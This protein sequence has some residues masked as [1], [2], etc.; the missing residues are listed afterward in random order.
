MGV[1][2]RSGIKIFAEGGFLSGSV[3]KA[4]NILSYDDFKLFS[5]LKDKKYDEECIAVIVAKAETYLEEPIP[6]LPLSLYRDKY[7]TGV[8][9][10]FEAQHHKRRDMLFYMA[11]AESYEKKGR[12]TVKI[13]DLAWAILEETTWVIPAHT[14]H[15]PNDPTSTVPETFREDTVPALDLYSA[16]CCALLAVVKYLLGEEL[17]KISPYICERIDRQ[18]YLRG[19]RPFITVSYGWSGEVPGFIDNWLTNITSNILTASALTTK[20]HSLRKRVT[21]RAMK[22]LDN[23]TAYY[24]ED[25]C[26]D[27]GPGYWGG[28]GASLM[29]CLELIE[30]IS[31]GKINVY[32]NPLIRKMGEYIARF[33]IDGKYYLNFA[34]ARPRLEQDGKLI[35]RYGEKCGSEQLRRFGAMVS[36]ENNPNRYY[37][38][39]M[40]YRVLK[41]LYIER[42]PEAEKTKAERAVWYDAYRIA[43][44]RESEDTSQGFFL[45]TKGGDNGEMHNHNDVGCL[46]VYHGGKPVIVDPSHGSYDNGFF[47]P[48]RYDRWFM[49]SSYHSI[50]LANGV[51][52]K[53]GR[54]FKSTDEVC[55]LDNMTVSMNLALAFPEDA[56]I[57]KMIRTV[58]LDGSVV[59]VKDEVTL[60]SDGD[61]RFNYVTVDE[62]KVIAD[63]KLEIA[64]GRVFEYD[65]EKLTLS[66]EKVEN[67]YLPYDDLNFRGTW[68]RDCLW[69]IVLKANGKEAV[70]D[71]S[72]I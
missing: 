47:G 40:T 8:R 1:V 26:C 20:E 67:T 54:A 61:I 33:N 6:F 55:D 29:D 53:A 38:F 42:N 69:R 72:I 60:K 66:V 58:A 41:N 48:T 70:A 9:S 52:E 45:A 68:D 21:E 12:F 14:Y 31:G 16:N 28:A 71:I 2:E 11:M 15:S 56:G 59:R 63:G 24:P 5:D 44:F 18:I 7:L 57:D 62:P 36:A 19:I 17:D 43:I 37:F 35:I 30:D 10:R 13:A 27:E 22:F 49:K 34:D 32:S 39:G 23:F 51:E 50:P 65:S 46:V 3:T 25:G 4:D 64:E